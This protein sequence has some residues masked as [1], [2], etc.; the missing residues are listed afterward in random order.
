LLLNL[1]FIILLSTVAIFLSK[2]PHIRPEVI[3]VLCHEAG[4]IC[5]CFPGVI[6]KYREQGIALLLFLSLL[7]P[8]P[9]LS[10]LFG[11][12]ACGPGHSSTDLSLSRLC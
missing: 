9:E 7:L 8:S 6:E 1:S 12:K 4:N 3:A 10:S 11:L 5:C 2:K